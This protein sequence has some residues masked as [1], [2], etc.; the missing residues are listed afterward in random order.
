VFG[1]GAGRA[2]PR[3][4]GRQSP[5]R[6]ISARTIRAGLLASAT[7]TGIGGLR[8]GI[9]PGQVPG[10]AVAWGPL[11]DDAEGPDDPQSPR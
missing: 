6:A 4:G 7:R 8:V 5:P 9:P 2:P 1:T 3:P 11:D 10:R